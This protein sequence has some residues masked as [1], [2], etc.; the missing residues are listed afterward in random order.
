MSYLIL[1]FPLERC[2]YCRFRPAKLHD[3]LV[4]KSTDLGCLLVRKRYQDLEFPIAGLA[5]LVEALYSSAL[6]VEAG[7]FT[8]PYAFTHHTQST[9]MAP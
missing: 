9:N 7:F 1:P 5:N 2:S 6:E 8:M 3:S 4:T